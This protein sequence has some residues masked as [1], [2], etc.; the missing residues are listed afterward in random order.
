MLRV[1]FLNGLPEPAASLCI[2]MRE[3]SVKIGAILRPILFGLVKKLDLRKQGGNAEPRNKP[4]LIQWQLQSAVA[5][6]TP[7][8]RCTLVKQE[9]KF[10]GSAVSHM[11]LI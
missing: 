1:K 3:G 11:A 8:G 7:M 10:L 5:A 9:L 6:R 2:Q 4:H